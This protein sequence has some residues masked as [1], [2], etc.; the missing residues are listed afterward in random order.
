MNART[1]CLAALV[2]AGGCAKELHAPGTLPGEA[3]GAVFV[4]TGPLS[5]HTVHED[6]TDNVRDGVLTTVRYSAG[7]AIGMT[8]FGTLTGLEFSGGF[9]WISGDAASLEPDTEIYNAYAD[10]EIGGIIQPIM[11]RLGPVNARAL[12]DFGAGT[13]LDDRYLYAGARLG[14]GAHSRRWAVDLSAR[15]RFG[16][17]PGNRDAHDDRAGVFV[18]R[19]R[20]GGYRTV[21]VGL[22]LIRGDQR[23]LDDGVE[24]ARDDYRLRGRYDAIMITIGYGAAEPPGKVKLRGS[25]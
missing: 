4:S 25:W 18:T 3:Q 23:V 8:R 19:R 5:S 2:V 12:F 20:S 13:S 6:G 22:E 1:I 7:V 9:G 17:T 11:W 24:R 15:R 16:D 10:L 14:L 21:H